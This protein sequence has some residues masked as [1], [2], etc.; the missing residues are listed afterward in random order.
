MPPQMVRSER[1][2]V[3]CSSDSLNTWTVSLPVILR[4][5]APGPSITSGPAVSAKFNGA[6]RVIESCVAPVK[7]LESNSISLPTVFVLAL[8]W[9]MQ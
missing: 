4:A 7:T 8:A 1:V 9:V 3:T 2:A 5:L 6:D